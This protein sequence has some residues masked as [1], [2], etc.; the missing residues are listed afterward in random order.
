MKYYQEITLIDQAEISP[1]FHLVKVLY[2][3]AYCFG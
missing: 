3:V 2:A 1:Y